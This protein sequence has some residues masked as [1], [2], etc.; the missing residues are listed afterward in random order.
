M[1][2]ELGKIYINR[3]QSKLVYLYHYNPDTESGTEYANH[4][5]MGVLLPFRGSGYHSGQTFTEDGLFLKK[6]PKSDKDIVRL[7]LDNEIIQT[8]E[9]F[10]TAERKINLPGVL[11][12]LEKFLTHWKGTNEAA[13]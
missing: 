7:A 12:A 8:L 3:D 9:N 4:K 2:V 13:E 6:Y 1:K 11:E 10:E 5:Y